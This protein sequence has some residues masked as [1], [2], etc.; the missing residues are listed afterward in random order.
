MNN[1]KKNIDNVPERLITLS[2]GTGM[3]DILII[4]STNAPSDLLRNLEKE[5]CNIYINGG[6]YDD[7]PIWGEVLSNKG[8]TFEYVDS[9]PHITPYGTSTDWLENHELGSKIREHYVI[10]NQPNK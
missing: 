6:G 1:C 5:S 4:F 10:E 8:Y 9:H 3:G 7:V 2:D